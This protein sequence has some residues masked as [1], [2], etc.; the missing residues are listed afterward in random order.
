MRIK[1]I[2]KKKGSLLVEKDDV[3][4][5]H[6]D[7]VVMPRITNNIRKDMLIIAAELA[8][9]FWLPSEFA[10]DYPQKTYTAGK[11]AKMM[12]KPHQKAKDLAYKLRRLID[13]LTEA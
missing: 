11:V 1:P 8:Q 10:G 12:E 9:G 3:A 13:E 6:V 5:F 2:R 4:Q 7:P